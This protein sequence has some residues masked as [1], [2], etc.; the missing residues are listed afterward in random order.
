[1]NFNT[2]F[3]VICFFIF[4]FLKPQAS[5]SNDL[6]AF[7]LAQSQNNPGSG[8]FEQEQQL[9]DYAVGS[10]LRS[11]PRRFGLRFFGAFNFASNIKS[12]VASNPF[13][14]RGGGLGNPFANSSMEYIFPHKEVLGSFSFG[15]SVFMFLTNQ[16]GAIA[17]LS[18][19]LQSKVEQYKYKQYDN[20]YGGS[21]PVA[22]GGC[23]Q[24][25]R[26]R[27]YFLC[28]L[29]EQFWYSILSAEVSA[30]YQVMPM[31]YI[32]A[33]PNFFIPIGFRTQPSGR[34]RFVGGSIPPK[35]TGGIGGQA[36][37]GGNFHSFFME[38]LF[39]TQNMTLEGITISHNQAERLETGRLWGLMIRGGIQI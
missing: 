36:G 18:F 7:L 4:L 8:S 13:F 11:S 20:S 9:G 6:N 21:Q 19:E 29:S 15:G 27:E 17:T 30:Q 31:I 14:G 10:S 3:Y 25:S 35:I 33:G 24:S 12:H 34:G 38:V 37:I 39:K 26:D 28:P 32:F 22:R 5:S 2:I 16:I 23:E 1:M